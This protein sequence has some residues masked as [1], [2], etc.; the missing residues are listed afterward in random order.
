MDKQDTGRRPALILAAAVALGALAP[1]FSRARAP[2]PQ[3]DGAGRDAADGAVDTSIWGAIKATAVAVS[4]DRLTS[5]AAGSAFFIL[6]AI[7]PALTSLVSVYGLFADPKSI[8]DNVSALSGILPGGGVQVMTDEL[9]RVATQGRSSL[10]LALAFGLVVSLWSANSGMKAVVDALNVAFDDPEER[11]FLRLNALTLLFTLLSLVFV[12]AML[13]ILIVLPAALRD[14][15]VGVKT[16]RLISVARWPALYVVTLFALAVLYRFG[17]NRRHPRWRWATW[18]SFF[19]TT[20]WLIASAGFSYYAAHFGSFDKTYGSLGAVI[21]FMMW[22]WISV[23]IV[24]IGAELDHQLEL[25][26][27]RRRARDGNA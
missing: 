16:D 11:S 27:R 21:G 26:A 1:D 22:L 8:S 25:R 13:A 6:F 9:S 12:V 14:I 17:P 24:L 2:A 20:V 15:G 4:D 19:A 18:G 5:V 3:A 23:T 7:F 10:S